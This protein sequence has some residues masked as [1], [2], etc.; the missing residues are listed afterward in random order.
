MTA[1][2]PLPEAGSIAVAPSTA[3]QPGS[4]VAAVEAVSALAILCGC[5]LRAWFLFHDP[6]TADESVVGLMAR[7]IQ[8]GHVYAFFWGQPFGG[9]EPY[10]VAA[11]F[12]VAGHSGLTLIL[13]PVLLSAIGALLVWRIAKRF[14]ADPRL[15]VLAGALAWAA[16]L[17]VVYQSTVEGG[18]RGVVLV[19]GLGLILLSARILDGHSGLPEFV[20]LGLLVGIGWWAIPEIVYFYLPSLLLLAG[21]FLPRVR[22]RQWE[23]MVRRTA[24]TAASA[25]VGGLPWLW[26]NFHSGFASLHTGG[27]PGASSPGNPGFLGRLRLFYQAALPLQLDLRREASG[28]WVFGVAGASSLHRSVLVVVVVVVMLAVVAGIALCLLHRRRSQALAL[29][30]LA[31]PLLVALQPGTWSWQDGRYTTYLGWFLA[32]ATAIASEEAGRLWSRGRSRPARGRRPGDGA[33][34]WI[35]SAGVALILL[36]AIA[37]FHE[38]FG[39]GAASYVEAWAVPDGTVSNTAASLEAHQIVDGYA[40]YWV[41]Y[42]LDFVSD[43]R[44]RLTVDGSDPNRVPGLSAAVRAA[45]SQSWLFLPNDPLAAAHQFGGTP[46]LV[47]PAGISEGRFTQQLMRRGVDY[48]TERVGLFDVVTPARGVTLEQLGLSA[49]P[50]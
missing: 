21:A 33:A 45:P 6:V 16:P 19:C 1:L 29:S 2:A 32:L 43:G 39:V 48:R 34:R 20:A 9:V 18:F 49:P 3:R 42:D 46:T 31:F 10:V 25:V 40:D 22:A 7:S 5:A 23:W 36:L 38:S 4:G 28:K 13:V 41:A 17:P 15:A 30:I 8:H 12:T 26:A 11:M 27:F 24:L 47:G 44:L 37:S 50:R 35:M 14:V